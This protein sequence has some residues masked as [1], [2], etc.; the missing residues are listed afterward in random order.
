MYLMY[1]EI[2][3]FY[4]LGLL[5]TTIGLR[6]TL[7]KTNREIINYITYNKSLFLFLSLSLS[8]SL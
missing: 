8:L 4:V 2:C 3:L 7:T 1:I 5:D 6:N